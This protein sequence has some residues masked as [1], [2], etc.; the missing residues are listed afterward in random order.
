M[1]FAKP[2]LFVLPGVAAVASLSLGQGQKPAPASAPPIA[3][4]PGWGDMHL[5]TKIGS[6]KLVDG[7]GRVEINFTGSVLVS[8]LKG[9]VTPS[10]G[11]RKEYDA[12]DRQVYHGTGKLTVE[13]SF[14]G[15]QWF[16]TN[17]ST[18]WIGAG[19]ARIVGEFDKNLETGFYWYGS[20]V[21]KKMP[22]SSSG[23]T[24]LNPEARPGGTGTPVP[25][26]R[27]GGG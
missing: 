11:I 6:F 15:I 14:R 10:A 26:S 16:G 22:W 27:S 19:L 1:R 24:I 25:R 13:G 17:M 8:K 4:K 2:L 20:G 9:R 18:R 21:D 7:E 5:A 12:N 23:M 3:M